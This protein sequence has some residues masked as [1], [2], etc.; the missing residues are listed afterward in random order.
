M[1]A[2]ATPDRLTG[3]PFLPIVPTCAL[4][5]RGG[6]GKTLRYLRGTAQLWMPLLTLD[7]LETWHFHNG[8]PST[9]NPLPSP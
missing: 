8:L 1:P 2:L 9:P 3:F 6:G 5:H 7:A 4:L